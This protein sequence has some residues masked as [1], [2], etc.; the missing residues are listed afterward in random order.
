MSAVKF[1]EAVT[2]VRRSGKA[3]IP[4]IE[5]DSIHTGFEEK[6]HPWD[7][8][9]SFLSA[10]GEED[11]KQWADHH[12]GQKRL[13]CCPDPKVRHFISGV[14]ISIEESDSVTHAADDVEFMYINGLECYMV[15]D[16]GHPGREVFAVVI[17]VDMMKGERKEAVDKHPDMKLQF[18]CV[19]NLVC[20]PVHRDLFTELRGVDIQ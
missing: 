1:P 6:P 16:I 19:G 11:R 13:H 7:G 14:I 18:R 3:I 2:L 20:L 15:G 10:I 4:E 17:D 5:H 12:N 8:G 9:W